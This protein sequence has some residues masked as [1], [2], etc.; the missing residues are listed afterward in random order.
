MKC[1]EKYY[2]GDLEDLSKEQLID[3]IVYLEDV[4][5]RWGKDLDKM[6]EM[7]RESHSWSIRA[8]ADTAKHN[9]ENTHGKSP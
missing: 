5:I 6:H 3:K 4:L 1:W 7:K 8:T 9:R 2:E